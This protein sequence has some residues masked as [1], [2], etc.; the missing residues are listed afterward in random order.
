MS[1]WLSEISTEQW[2]ALGSVVSATAGALMAWIALRRTRQDERDDCLQKLKE[3]RRE[4]EQMADEL[5]QLRMR[6]AREA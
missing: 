4:S 1:E 5:H 3:A 2:A 6:R